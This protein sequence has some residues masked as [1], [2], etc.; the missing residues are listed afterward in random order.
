MASIITAHPSSSRENF[1]FMSATERS[2][3]KLE[4]VKRR[5]K[6]CS[7]APYG[8]GNIHII[9]PPSTLLPL[10]FFALFNEGQ[11]HLFEICLEVASL[12]HF[13]RLFEVFPTQCA[14]SPKVADFFF[15]LHWNHP[16]ET[17]RVNK[18]INGWV[19]HIWGKSVHFSAG[20]WPRCADDVPFKTLMKLISLI[21]F[22]WCVRRTIITKEDLIISRCGHVCMFSPLLCCWVIMKS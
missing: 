15:S 13:K 9:S 3:G 7:E 11:G 2:D 6:N 18:F 20:F 16:R 1:R 8:W 12:F 4:F 10:P 21:V 19:Q 5:R 22:A 14:A 17:R